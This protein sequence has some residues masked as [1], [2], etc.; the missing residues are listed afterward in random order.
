MNA[1]LHYQSNEIDGPSKCGICSTGSTASP[2]LGL[3]E[4]LAQEH[5]VGGDDFSKAKFY[6]FMK[7]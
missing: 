7:P 4:R 1:S 6:V 3:S 2:L 5:M